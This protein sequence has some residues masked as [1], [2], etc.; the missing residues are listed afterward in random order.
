MVSGKE[1]FRVCCEKLKWS[2]DKGH[3]NGEETLSVRCTVLGIQMVTLTL[4][5]YLPN[6]TSILKLVG[7]PLVLLVI[8]LLTTLQ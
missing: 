2:E 4:S 8:F 6:G 3:W 7:N 5:S 1:R